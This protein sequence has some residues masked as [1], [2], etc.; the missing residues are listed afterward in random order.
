MLLISYFRICV[1]LKRSDT[2]EIFLTR[3]SR[4]KES[5]SLSYVD[6]ISSD[7]V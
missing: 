2:F 4:I 3:V 6:D 7:S 5:K 1:F